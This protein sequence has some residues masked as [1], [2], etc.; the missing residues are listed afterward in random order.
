MQPARPILFLVSA[1]KGQA[2]INLVFESYHAVMAPQISIK[3]FTHN[4]SLMTEI[5]LLGV[6][7]HVIG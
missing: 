7:N 3:I 1:T 2:G 6:N 4:A 5:Y